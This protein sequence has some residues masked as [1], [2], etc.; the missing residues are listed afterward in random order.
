LH[1]SVCH[2]HAEFG[3]EIGFVLSGL[4]EKDGRGREREGRAKIKERDKQGMGRGT[5]SKV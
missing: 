1:S 3:F 5:E 4:R 2:I